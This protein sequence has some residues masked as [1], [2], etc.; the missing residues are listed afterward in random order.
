MHF[1]ERI[2]CTCQLEFDFLS[3]SFR[4]ND[5]TIFCIFHYASTSNIGYFMN[6]SQQIGPP[7]SAEASRVSLFPCLT[8]FT[9]KAVSPLRV[10][11]SQDAVSFTS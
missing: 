6:I 7:F 9:V 11:T 5:N 2:S 10:T 3:A 8:A 4:Y 1:T